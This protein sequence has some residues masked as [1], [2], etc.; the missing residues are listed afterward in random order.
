[1]GE[2]EEKKLSTFYFIRHG[3]SVNNLAQLVN[4]WTDCDLTEKGENSAA[5]AGEMLRDY[6]I[7]RIVTSDLKRALKTAEIIADKI[8]FIGAIETY[9]ELR[10]RNWGVYE[11][12]PISERPGLNINPEKGESWEVFYQRVARKLFDVNLDENTLL[13]GHAGIYRVIQKIMFNLDN[14]EKLNNCQPVRIE[15]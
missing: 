2:I 7:T 11:N 4:G 6:N 12:K 5:M 1:M 3:E 9:S 13:V 10:E 14:Q 8:N 15:I